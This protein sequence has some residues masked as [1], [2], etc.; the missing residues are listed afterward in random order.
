[1][2]SLVLSQ[3]SWSVDAASTAL[4]SELVEAR[5]VATRRQLDEAPVLVVLPQA[6]GAATSTLQPI[7]AAAR[8]AKVWLAGAARLQREDGTVQVVITDCP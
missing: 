3:S 5:A 7:G 6:S 2:T 4:V 1:M 8:E